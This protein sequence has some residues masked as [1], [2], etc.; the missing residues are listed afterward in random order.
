MP[1]EKPQKSANSALPCGV[2]GV[3]VIDAQASEADALLAKGA[4]AVRAGDWTAAERWLRQSLREDPRLARAHALMGLVYVKEGHPSE[5]LLELREAHTIEPRNPDYAYDYAVLLV[6]ARHFAPAVPILEELHHQSPSSRDVLVNLARAYA[7]IRDR[8][9]LSDLVKG[10]PGQCYEDEDFLKSLAELLATAREDAAVEQLWKGAIRRNPSQQ[11]PYA[12][13]AE[14]WLGEGKAKQALALLERAPSEAQGPVY[15]YAYGQV[16]LAV[17]HPKAAATAFLRLTELMPENER[18]WEA[19]I[20]AQMMDD[21]FLDAEESAQ[22]AASRFPNS[23]QFQYQEAVGDYL[24]GRSAAAVNA[25]M[26][27][28]GRE[29]EANDPRAILL[30]AVLQAENGHYEEALRYFKLLPRRG[31]SC[32]ALASYFYGTTL[33]RM[34]QPGEATFQLR[35]ALQCHPHFALAE[36]RLGQALLQ[37]NQPKAALARFEQATR[38]DPNLAEPYYALAQV[39]QRLGDAAG[40]AAAL[41]RFHRLHQHVNESGRNLLRSTLGQSSA[42]H[43]E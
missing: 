37:A 36:Y 22:A 42:R 2:A 21:H 18:G 3:Q 27:A 39:R 16:Q 33:L 15:L 7:G 41:D 31:G 4:A 32:N 6:E 12:A 9:K 24:L 19:L 17:Q 29:P 14:L 13:L 35:L 40:A 28:L 20:R 30:M 10:L 5:A 43:E 8:E 23:A 26:P 34:H 11:L 38:D 25:L 1:A